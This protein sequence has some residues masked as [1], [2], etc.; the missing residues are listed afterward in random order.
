VEHAK[1]WPKSVAKQIGARIAYFREQARDERGRKLTAQGLAARCTEL[2]LPIGRPAIAK[3]ERGLRDT[4]TVTELH[5]L[6][7]ALNV[8]PADL[9]F[10]LGQAAEVEVLP[11]EHVDTWDAVLWFSGFAEKPG[12]PD[13]DDEGVVHLYQVHH[14]IMQEW[15]GRW[16]GPSAER[17]GVTGLRRVRAEIQRRGLLLPPLPPDLAYVDN[18]EPD[19]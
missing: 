13:E 19:E 10:P 15:R 17:M 7:K 12:R 3:M 6:A 8:S 1:D 11:G 4:I 2:G 5:V 14:V 18:G 16:A 9:M